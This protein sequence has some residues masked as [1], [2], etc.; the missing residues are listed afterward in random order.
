MAIKLTIGTE[1]S[2]INEQNLQTSL[3]TIAAQL[4]P[5]TPVMLQNY[6]SSDLGLTRGKHIHNILFISDGHLHPHGTFSHQ[7]GKRNFA[8]ITSGY[9]NFQEY[10]IVHHWQEKLELDHNRLTI[11]H[12]W[13]KEQFNEGTFSR[14]G[15]ERWLSSHSAGTEEIIVGEKLLEKFPD[16]INSLK[17]AQEAINFKLNPFY[18]HLSYITTQIGDKSGSTGMAQQSLRERQSCDLACLKAVANL[19]GEAHQELSEFSF[20]GL[21][22]DQLGWYREGGKYLR[23]KGIPVDDKDYHIHEISHPRRNLAYVKV[24]KGL[25]FGETYILPARNMDKIVESAFTEERI[26]KHYPY[27]MEQKHPQPSEL[28]YQI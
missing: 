18:S 19:I 16:A 12:D 3:E 13:T 6:S 24:G 17:F 11:P 15:P 27:G 5:G 2:E 26:K 9:T 14:S 20:G 28:E 22:T 25:I 10:Q 7:K 8:F 21:S 4:T 23:A 1:Q